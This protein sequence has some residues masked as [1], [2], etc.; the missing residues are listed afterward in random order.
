MFY[1]FQFPLLSL[2][3]NHCFDIQ[4]IWFVLCECVSIDMEKGMDENV[5]NFPLR[6]QFFHS[7]FKWADPSVHSKI[8]GIKDLKDPLSDPCT[9]L[10]ANQPSKRIS[11]KD[12]SSLVTRWY[13]FSP[14]SIVHLHTTNPFLPNNF[15]LFCDGWMEFMVHCYSNCQAELIPLRN[16]SPLF[17]ALARI[18]RTHADDGRDE[19]AKRRRGEERERESEEGV[20]WGLSHLR[21][22]N[23]AVLNNLVRYLLFCNLDI[24]WFGCQEYVSQCNFL[25]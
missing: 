18:G 14:S 22:S 24:G 6:V 9:T 5:K 21:I 2:D 10:L 19:F 3:T 23:G 8:K 20:K 17:P 25:P 16:W 11:F 12:Q 13:P 1:L 7:I 4:Q 15:S